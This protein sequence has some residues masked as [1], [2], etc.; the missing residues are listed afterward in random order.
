MI[1]WIAEPKLLPKVPFGKHRNSSWSEVPMDYQNWMVGQ[2]D[3]DP[4]VIWC[5]Q[6]ELQERITEPVMPRKKLFSTLYIFV[7]GWPVIFG[8]VTGSICATP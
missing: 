5:A 7:H 6:R 1:A 8:S 3:M 4:D 2:V